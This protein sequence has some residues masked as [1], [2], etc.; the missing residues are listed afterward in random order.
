[1]TYVDFVKKKLFRATNDAKQVCTN[2]RPT[3]IH[4][5]LYRT[6]IALAFRRDSSEIDSIVFQEYLPIYFS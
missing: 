3:T 2:Q 1:M 4:V 5:K 6:K